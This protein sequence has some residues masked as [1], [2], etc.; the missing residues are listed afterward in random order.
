MNK[1]KKI[2]ILLF[3]SFI[4]SLFL[5]AFTVGQNNFSRDRT[6]GCSCH[7]LNGPIT[8][9]HNITGNYI[10]LDPSETF[11]IAITLSGHIF[12]NNKDE[13]GWAFW[14]SSG[15]GIGV[16]IPQ[17]TPLSTVN[18][19]AAADLH[20]HANFDANAPLGKDP[21]TEVYTITA[22]G[23]TGATYLDIKGVGTGPR[24]SAITQITI[25]VTASDTTPPTVTITAPSN[26]SYI[27]GASVAITGTVTDADSGV[28]GSSVEAYVTNTTGTNNTISLT[29]TGPSYSGTWD[30]TTVFDGDYNITVRAQDNNGNTNITEYVTIKVDNTA[31]TITIDSVVPDPSNGITTITATNSSSDIDGNG[32]RANISDPSSEEIYVNLNYQGSNIWNGTFTVTQNGNYNVY[33]NATD[34]AGNI[35]TVGPTTIEGDVADP[36]ITINS[37]TS[38]ALFSTTQPNFDVTISDINLNETWYTIDNGVSNITFSGS[39]G[40]IDSTEWN[41]EGNGTVTIRFYAND[42]AGNIFWQEVTVRKDVETPS[43]SIN[44]P[45]AND[46]IGVSAPSYDVTISDSS[47]ISS[48]WYTIDS[49]NTNYTFFGSTG[50][51]NQAAWNGEGNGTVIIRFYAND[52]AGN[53]FWQEVTVRK[54]VEAPSVSITSPAA[55]DL[56]GV[57]AS[58]YDVTIS[59]SSGISTQWYTIDSGSTNYTFSGSTGTINQA[60]WNGEGN[61][62][63]TI[64]FYANDTAGNVFWQEV[65]VR[66]DVEAPSVSITSPAANDLNGVSAPS[67]DV[68]ISDSSG[69]STQWYTIDSG[70]TNYTFSGST[71][72]INQAAWNGEGNG[73]VTIRFYANDTMGNTFWQE[74]TIRKDIEAPSISITNPTANELNGVSAPSYDATIS[75]SSGI[76]TQWYTID[77]GSTNYTF[78]GSTGTINQAAW[79]GETNGTVTIRFQLERMLK[80]PLFQSPVRLRMI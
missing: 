28:L 25:N 56:N 23:S 80:H 1:T 14:H 9:S 74:I 49:G 22:P 62:T 51:I 58:S 46:L 26:N 3:V 18:N 64:R 39:T 43:I 78:I 16:P 55:N 19:W 77:S 52:T 76:N 57:S 40:T 60:A 35:V 29:Y 50:T 30:S 11:D 8:L 73:T 65:T 47:G 31:P 53:V 34:L 4:L 12:G 72:T 5:L 44:S 70:S 42:T 41:Q 48:Q 59:D 37:P 63:V 6:D 17:N 61:G 69:I 67:Y 54:D 13:L 66:K 21:W 36:V 15:D 33:I 71:G 68:T 27:S 24:G 45:A 79:N 2:S 7:G 32:I 20:Y 75:D 10:E 38:N